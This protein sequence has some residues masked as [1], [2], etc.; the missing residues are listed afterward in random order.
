MERERGTPIAAH[1]QKP[2]Y[3]C[4]PWHWVNQINR[5]PGTRGGS[6]RNTGCCRELVP[7]CCCC[8]APNTCLCPAPVLQS[9]PTTPNLQPT[10]HCQWVKGFTEP[11]NRIIILKT[12]LALH[13][14]YQNFFSSSVL[15]QCVVSV[16]IGI[17]FSTQVCTLCKSSLSNGAMKW[18]FVVLQRQACGPQQKYNIA[19]NLCTSEPSI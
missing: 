1:S 3:G 8:T 5:H 12:A 6:R 2:Q 19:K 11:A 17:M 16:R 4:K 15:F 18:D 10:A 9:T 7:T 13:C 14:I